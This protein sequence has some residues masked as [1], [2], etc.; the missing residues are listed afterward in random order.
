MAKILIVDDEKNIRDHLAAYLR[1]LGHVAETAGDGETALSKLEREQFD[2]VL[3][4]V[5]MPGMNGLTLLR[6]FHRRQPDVVV[7]LM[8]AYA[9]VPQAVESMR[10]GAY[11]YLMKPFA[12]DDVRLL[13]NHI[14]E[15]RELRREQASVS[16]AKAPPAD[17][18]SPPEAP[19][20]AGVTQA[21]LSLRDL[22]RHRIEQ[23][24]AESPTLGEAAQRLGIDPATLWRKR[25]RYGIH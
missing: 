25:K 20:A 5:R 6:E 22:E 16:H 11:E 18:S 24:L 13:I 4:D 17:L 19:A 2:V 23:V 3:S 8:T 1:D 7:V 21:E 12:L 10:S 9:T 14:L 15:V